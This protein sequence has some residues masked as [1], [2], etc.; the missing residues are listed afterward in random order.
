MSS[1]AKSGSIGEKLLPQNQDSVVVIHPVEVNTFFNHYWEKK[2]LHIQRERNN[3]FASLISISDIESILSTVPLQFPDLQ[4][5]RASD[6]I[7]VDHYTDST[8]GI[9]SARVLEYYQQGASIVLSKAQN[10]HPPLMA[11]CRDIQRSFEM[12][13]QTNVYLSPPGMRGF[14]PHFD[15]HDVFVLQ[16]AG[17]KEFRFY[18]GSVNFPTA[19]D[20]FDPSRHKK[21]EFTES[22][23]MGEGD[24]LYIPRGVVHDAVASGE[25]ASL[26]VTLGVYPV[27]VQSLLEEML[28]IASG[29]DERLRKALP[30]EFWSSNQGRSVLHSELESILHDML[31]GNILEHAV[32]GV[33]DEFALQTIQECKDGLRIFQRTPENAKFTILKDAVLGTEQSDTEI[34]LRTFGTV[35]VF[36]AQFVPAVSWLLGQ[37]SFTINQ[38]PDLDED[39]KLNLIERLSAARVIILSD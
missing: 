31:A 1:D 5:S 13:C 6:P 16:V 3:P 14:N 28:Q 27:L 39:E 29:S 22:I 12:P 2:S 7:P 17:A 11:L 32:K 33:K 8:Q 37:D 26:H 25:F 19:V 24:T 9:V 10:L 38:I 15:T 18:E 20:R 34:E 4:L 30:Q 35:L 21:G 23:S 36:A